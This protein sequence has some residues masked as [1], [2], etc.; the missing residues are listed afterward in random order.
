MSFSSSLEHAAS[1][2]TQNNQECAEGLGRGPSSKNLQWSPAKYRS[3][4]IIH[5]NINGISTYASRIKLD[6]ILD[7]AESLEVQIIALQETKLKKHAKLKIKGYNI[8]RSDG[9]EGGGLAFLVRDINYRTID[10]PQFTDSELEIQRLNVI[11]KGKNLNISN[12]YHPPN[13]KSLPDNLLDISESNLLVGDL[14][15][16]HNSWGNVINNK[17]GVELHNLMDDSAHLA[18]NDGSPT[19]SSHSYHTEEA[20][21]VSIVSSDIFPFC[22]WT[23]LQDIGSDHLPILVELK[24]KQMT[25]L[26]K[27][28][29]WN[30]KKANWEKYGDTVDRGLLS[31]PPIECRS[32]DDL[33]ES[34]LSFKKIIFKAAGQAIPRGNYK[35]PSPFFMHKSPLLQPLLKKRVDICREIKKSNNPSLR[36]SLNKINAEIKRTFIH[37]KREKWKELCKSIDSHTPNTKLWKL[38]KSLSITQPQQE[39]CNTII[40]DNGQISSD[41]KTTAN[42]LGSYNQKT[43]KLTFN[44]MDKNTENYARKLVHG[45]RSSEHGIPIFKEFFTM[46]ELNIALSTLDPS[47]SPGSDNIHGQMIS[48]LS[49]WGKKSF[50][51]IFNLSWRLGRLPRDWKKALIIPIRKPS[52]KSSDPESFRPIALT[53]FSCKLIWKK[54][55]LSDLLTI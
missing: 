31:K 18:L 46:Q 29:F 7:I 9:Q 15:A 53:N 19:Y 22:K 2:V 26:V 8:I 50:L 40:D 12:M 48:R 41:N 39:E 27:K 38:M 54:L 33:D 16:K 37:L 55:F 42:L 3:L 24:W 44:A 21:D 1:L 35:R 14:N 32:I 43:S 17:R 30:F 52:K 5:C 25:Q 6:A 13:Q 45:C 49:D 28:K 4:K 34:W 51:E 20:L 11:W 36:S 10:N 47:K 23:V